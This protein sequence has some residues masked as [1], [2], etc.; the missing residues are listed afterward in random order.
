M[1][2]LAPEL[3]VF[4]FIQSLDAQYQKKRASHKVSD[5]LSIGISLVKIVVGSNEFAVEVG[6]AVET[7]VYKN[8]S[9]LPR[10]FPW[11]LGLIELRG[12]VMPV[13][14]LSLFSE[15]APVEI[16]SHTRLL[17]VRHEQMIFALVVSSVSPVSY[18]SLLL[19]ESEQAPKKLASY[20]ISF[21]K[22]VKFQGE[23]LHFLDLRN[24]ANQTGF[25]TLTY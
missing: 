19:D 15:Q 17:I 7:I 23:N 4:D 18:V 6:V 20:K 5:K 2:A 12:E 22:W 14:D 9:P 25:L 11:V 3:T 16:N 24:I 8:P 21:D 1:A 10:S 13:I